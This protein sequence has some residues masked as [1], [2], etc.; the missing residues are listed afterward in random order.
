MNRISRD[1][2]LYVIAIISDVRKVD[3]IR[4]DYDDEV[5]FLTGEETLMLEGELVTYKSALYN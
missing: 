5:L 4:P 3:V 2:A 1:R